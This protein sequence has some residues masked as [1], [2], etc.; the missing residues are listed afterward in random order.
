MSL[1]NIIAF[2]LSSHMKNKVWTLSFI[3]T[4]S[5]FINS[6]FFHLYFI[7]PYF[8]LIM[9]LLLYEFIPLPSKFIIFALNMS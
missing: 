9:F 2:I 1:L 4:N 3:F 7:Q 8:I 5:S 6:S